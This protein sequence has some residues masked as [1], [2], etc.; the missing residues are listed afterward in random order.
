MTLPLLEN[1]NESSVEHLADL[2]EQDIKQL[3]ELPNSR[4]DL[5]KREL[6]RRV[7][8]AE[9]EPGDRKAELTALTM[10]ELLVIARSGDYESITGEHSMR[11]V[12]LIEAILD[13]EGEQDASK[14]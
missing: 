3:G 13:V 4:R 2:I 6:D 11:K 9:V 14:E 10:A 5:V 8:S 7:L 12:Q 1:L